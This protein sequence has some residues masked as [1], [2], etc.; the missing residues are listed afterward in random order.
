MSSPVVVVSFFLL[1]ILTIWWAILGPFSPVPETESARYLWGGFYQIM[2]YWGGINGLLIARKWGGFKSILGRALLAFSIGLL[3]Q[4]FGQ[5]VY[6]FYLFYLGIEAP[7]PSLGDLG[8]FGTIPFYIYGVVLLARVIGVRVSVQSYVKKMQAVLIPVVMLV[9]SYVLFLRYYEFD[10][11][12]PI[13]TFLDFGYPL[14]QAIYVSLAILALLLSRNVLGGMM[15]YPIL[16]LLIA[17]VAQ[18]LA[19]YIFLYEFNKEEWY[20]GGLND[21]MYLFSY[22]LMA[23]GI[24]NVGVAFKRI[25]Q[26]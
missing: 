6:T 22:F 19:D 5:S 1:V 8:Y 10:F 3:C 7:Y 13:K 23:V 2:A 9:V 26:T 15:R 20:V 4:G 11:S 16:I 25:T 21:Y 17:L 24:A 14:G 18:Y 12:T